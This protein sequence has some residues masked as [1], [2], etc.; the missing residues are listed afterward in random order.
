MLKAIQ[1]KLGRRELVTAPSIITDESGW[2]VRIDGPKP[3]QRKGPISGADAERMQAMRQEF[4]ELM[5]SRNQKE[6]QLRSTHLAP[7]EF[8]ACVSELAAIRAR[9]KEL[10]ALLQ[11]GAYN[12]S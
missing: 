10:R 9:I 1:K 5:E 8:R 3:V 12:H 6:E 4:A 11:N 7:D 2:L